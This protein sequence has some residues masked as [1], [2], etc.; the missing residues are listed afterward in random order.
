MTAHL[1]CHYCSHVSVQE[2]I[3]LVEIDTLPLDRAFSDQ[4]T[5]FLQG[6]VTLLPGSQLHN[7]GWQFTSSLTLVLFTCHLPLWLTGLVCL[8]DLSATKSLATVPSS[9]LGEIDSSVTFPPCSCSSLLLAE[10]VTTAKPLTGLFSS[11]GLYKS[12]PRST[13]TGS[14][15][16]TA[17]ARC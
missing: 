1:R 8:I 2:P 11:T 5:D 15:G 17:A 10:R 7:S 6:G 4:A 12:Q 13:A 14:S 16:A 9:D 3:L